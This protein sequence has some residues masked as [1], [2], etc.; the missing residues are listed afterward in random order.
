MTD[1]LS[2]GSATLELNADL[3]QLQ[4]D[5]DAAKAKVATAAAEMQRLLDRHVEVSSRRLAIL[6]T[7]VQR[8][9]EKP[10]LDIRSNLSEWEAEQMAALAGV[11]ASIDDTS[12][13]L[14]ALGVSAQTSSAMQIAASHQARD[15]YLEEAAAAKAA[16]TEGN[17]ALAEGI[18]GRTLSAL[19]G[20][21]GS[22]V[23]VQGGHQAPGIEG[24]HLGIYGVR[25]P[26]SPGS[27]SNPIAV[28][29][30]AGARTPLGALAA[31]VGFDA[32]SSGTTTGTTTSTVA[33]A[34]RTEGARTI[35]TASGRQETSQSGRAVS[36]AE[37]A[38][39]ASRPGGASSTGNVPSDIGLLTDLTRRSEK[40]ADDLTLAA[41]ASKDAAESNKKT[42]AD[43]TALAA[44]MALGDRR[45]KSAIIRS[46]AGEGRGADALTALAASSHGGGGG[47]PGLVAGLGL[48]GGGGGGEGALRKLLWGP[49]AFGL[50][51]LATA[52]SAGSFAGLGFEHWL[53]TALGIGGSAAGAL[54]GG[55][56]LGA[57]A[58]SSLGVGVGSDLGVSA[59]A[60]SDTSSLY[61]AYEKLREAVAQYGKSSTQ[62]KEA[63]EEL[64]TTMKYT[65]SGTTG[66]AAELRLAQQVSH[67]NVEWDKMTSHAREE[68][69]QIAEQ[70]VKLAESYMPRVVSAAESNLAIIDKDIRPLFAWLE[71]PEGVGI[72]ENLE[73]VFRE[74]LPTGIHIADLGLQLFGK[75]VSDA[76][77]YTGGFEQKIN[78]LFTKWDEPQHFAVWHSEMEALIHDFHVW[79]AFLDA[80]GGSVVDLFEHDAHTGRDLIETL[81]QMLD[82]LRAWENSTKGG[83]ELHNLFTIHREETIALLK[84]LESLISPFAK[85]YLQLAPAAVPIVTDLADALAA[86]VNALKEMGPAMEDLLGLALIAG[87][88]GLLGNALRFVGVQLG[89]VSAESRTLG[90]M[91]ADQAVAATLASLQARGIAVGAGGSALAAGTT[92]AESTSLLS[93][94]GL[95]TAAGTLS[96]ATMGESVLPT[97][98]KGGLYGLGGLLVGNT[99][100]SLV[101]AHGTANTSLSLAGAGAGIGTAIEPGLGTAIGAGLGAATPYAIKF[102]DEVFS[103]HATDYGKA[104]AER[105]VTPLGGVLT[106]S[107]AQEY[108]NALRSE[109]NRTNAAR[110]EY[111]YSLTGARQAGVSSATEQR[112]GFNKLFTDEL[113]EGLTAAE[114]LKHALGGISHPTTIAF[115][116]DVTRQLSGLP[117]EAQG[118]AAEA[119][120]KYAAEL[121]KQ[122]K[123]PKGAVEQLIRALESRFSTLGPYFAEHADQTSRSVAA[124]LQ[125]HDAESSLGKTIHNLI[126]IWGIFGT[127]VELKNHR[128]VQGVG[129]AMNEM[130]EIAAHTTGQTREEALHNLHELEAKSHV[131]FDSMLG[132]FRSMV[133]GWE[134][135]LHAHLPATVALAETE[136]TKFANAIQT[137]VSS[138]ALSVQEGSKEIAEMLS[139]LL[140]PLGGTPLTGAIVAIKALGLSG[141]EKLGAVGTLA[142]L[143]KAAGGPCRWGVR[144]KPAGIQS[145][146]R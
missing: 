81:T 132:N 94:V 7:A 54:G 95:P 108:T 145:P 65:L 122:G 88:L 144:A 90:E 4:A 100:A 96:L 103:T 98:L 27:I 123:L 110:G 38:A 128:F 32:A 33:G 64:N 138:G 56:L 35:V 8:G 113:R 124:K 10:L 92:E 53:F 24:M 134:G 48:G 70:G 50:G 111:A 121:E 85:I 76:A 79:G 84:A 21:G 101:G 16:H 66:V 61:K 99:A 125:M 136:F 119:M 73:R 19:L 115:V 89:V 18:F 127:E 130:R 78:A 91:N 69:V 58:L 87:K 43:L 62:A 82:K 30:E 40:A 22:R 36:D 47:G 120:V 13:S 106:K 39:L 28:V 71:G 37:L 135:A 112:A 42:N 109:R 20:G 63:Q 142:P 9:V 57:G 67:L 5:L 55:A 15:A 68:F 107:T 86:I 49:G 51:A 129:T 72:F 25:G 105:F 93:R 2:L 133:S 117:H 80:L 116:A 46:L 143:K 45:Q 75:T 60:V 131:Y 126:G 12:K 141:A 139:A 17:A 29:L 59:S 6:G 31:A 26:N 14:T 83:E 104:F 137:G 41:G 74:N 52:G 118:A 1:G 102:L 97:L 77:D 34:T 140:K 114:A 11:R 44:A 23:F 3:G 146:C